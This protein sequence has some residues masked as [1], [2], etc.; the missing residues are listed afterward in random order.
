MPFNHTLLVEQ[1]SETVH[2]LSDPA[3][4]E[5]MGFGAATPLGR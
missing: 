5:R 2:F 3:R 1:A 4:R